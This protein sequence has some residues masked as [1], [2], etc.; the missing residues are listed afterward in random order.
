VENKPLVSF[1]LPT[2]D[3][4]EWVGECLMTL[5]GQGEQNIEIVVV[6]DGSTDGTKDFLEEWASKNPKV[7]LIHNEK[8][9]GAGN[10]RNIGMQAA[11]ADIIAV[12]DDDDC[13]PDDRAE[14]IIEFF[15]KNPDSE[16]VNFPYVSIGY[17]NE[18][19]ERFN[20]ET[21]D[22]K[23]F[24][25]K[26]M[27]NYFSNPTVA[28]KKAAVMEMGGY[29]NETDKTTDDSQF[30]K[31]WIDT[32]HKVDFNGDAWHCFHRILPDSMMVK[33]RG[34]DRKWVTK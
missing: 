24:K 5:M 16:L 17:C 19:L 22:H 4:E 26:E 31:K 15:K 32:G 18:V 33:H 34:F 20:G 2:K 6:N 10:S 7:K 30:L 8:S 9:V 27:V 3:R 11:S 12:C 25:E 28:Y 21:F 23:T 14:N 1:V 29:P 13:Y